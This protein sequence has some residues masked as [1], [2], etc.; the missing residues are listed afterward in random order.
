MSYNSQNI[1]ILKDLEPIQTRPGMFIGSTEYATHLLIEAIDNALD[2]FINNY[3]SRIG[4]FIDTKKHQYTVVDNGRG[5]PLGKIDNLYTP[6][7]LFTQL[8]SG[9]KFSKQSYKISTGLHG[10]GLGAITGLSEF[11]EVEIYRKDSDINPGKMTRG[12]FVFKK[13]QLHNEV[14]EI[15]EGNVPYSTRI[16]FKPDK[17]YFDNID[18]DVKYIKNKLLIAS[19]FTDNKEIIFGLDGKNEIIKE[20]LTEYFDR[21]YPIEKYIM[22]PTFYKHVLDTGE[23]I[24]LMMA[25]TNGNEPMK[26]SSSVNLLPTVSGTHVN[27]LYDEIR[28]IYDPY[29]KNHIFNLTGDVFVGFRCYFNIFLSDTSFDAQT[30]GKLTTNKN[31]LEPIFKGLSDHVRQ[32]MIKDKILDKLLQK[33]D[34]YRSRLKVKNIDKNMDGSKFIRGRISSESKLVD[35]KQYTN[36]ELFIIEGDSAGGTC[37]NARNSK[38]HAILPLKGKVLNVAS[39]KELA[40]ILKNNEI[41]DIIRSLGCGYKSNTSKVDISKL[42]YEKIILTADADADGKHINTL[43]MTIFMIMIPEVIETGH[44]YIADMPLFGL[45][46]KNKFIPCWDEKERDDNLKLYPNAQVTRFKGLGEMNDDELYVCLFDKKHRRLHQVAPPNE[47][48]K[49]KLIKLL[50]DSTERK[51]LIL[52]D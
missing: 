40:Q 30:K 23:E 3:A 36:S 12:L 43:L 33:F 52:E 9:G 26:V 49:E 5:I 51:K 2:E 44:L 18:V 35:C 16:T 14:L 45:K 24:Q 1:K 47:E 39:K 31:K 8:F 4:I 32:I 15:Y 11:V 50:T 46:T 41:R 38:I 27:M 34:D 13:G 22:K 28:K 20:N 17:K 37:A 42:R 21:L 6:V 7:V 25:Y 48:E 29:R 19:V 10:V